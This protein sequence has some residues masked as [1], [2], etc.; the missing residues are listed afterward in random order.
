M[1]ADLQTEFTT[2]RRRRTMPVNAFVELET[3]LRTGKPGPRNRVISVRQFTRRDARLARMSNDGN[4]LS[5]SVTTHADT[6]IDSQLVD[7]RYG[8]ASGV[9]IVDE[10]RETIDLDPSCIFGDDSRELLRDIEAKGWRT[11]RLIS[12]IAAEPVPVKDSESG[13][14]DGQLFIPTSRE[15]KVAADAAA[16]GSQGRTLSIRLDD[17]TLDPS[18]LMAWLNSDQGVSIRRTAIGTVSAG[19]AII[20]P[21]LDSRFLMSW[22]DELDVPVPDRSTQLALASA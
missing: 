8:N 5:W 2:E 7:S 10:V 9:S 16:T 15:G 20:R 19:G 21:R 6:P 1:I 18:F 14:T 3:G 11:R 17:D 4:R 12:L 22:A 13:E